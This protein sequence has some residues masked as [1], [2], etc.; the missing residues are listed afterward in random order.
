[1][2]L[3]FHSTF[4]SST[5]PLNQQSRWQEA[6]GAGGLVGRVDAVSRAKPI[7]E[8][9]KLSLLWTNVTRLFSGG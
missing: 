1:M 2:H 9:T 7:I 8:R 3:C 6:R 4:Y 5:E